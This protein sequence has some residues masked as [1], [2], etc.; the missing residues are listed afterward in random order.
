MTPAILPTWR[1]MFARLSRLIACGAGSGLLSPA[2]GTWGSLLGWASGVWLL[3]MVSAVQFTLIVGAGFCVGIWACTRTGIHLGSPDHSCMVIDEI[4]AFWAML[5]FLPASWGWQL[6]G[7]ISF[8]VFDI[9]KPSPISAIDQWGKQRRGWTC[10]F[11]VMA[12]DVMAA[13]YALL[14][15]AIALRL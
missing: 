2:P 4:V 5:L 13:F 10:G 1:W 6:F 12:D 7:F 15:V 3:S 8:R 9:L 14:V 11:A